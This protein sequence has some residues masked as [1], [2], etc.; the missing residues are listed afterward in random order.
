M[1]DLLEKGVTTFFAAWLLAHEMADDIIRDTIKKG[2]M[3]PGEKK[4][5]LDEFAVE[6][7]KEKE[8]LKKRIPEVTHKAL[9]EVGLVPAEEVEKM[10]ARI[11]ALEKKI[12]SMEK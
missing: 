1:S 7:E 6:V 9:K 10:K 2:K 3:T 4:K 12:A 5:F 8:D 11:D